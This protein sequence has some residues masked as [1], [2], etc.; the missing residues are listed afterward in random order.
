MPPQLPPDLAWPVTNT[1]LA[2]ALGD[3]MEYVWLRRSPSQPRRHFL[4]AAWIPPDTREDFESNQAVLVTVRPVTDESSETVRRVVRGDLLSNLAAWV[5]AAL[6]Q[7]EE[8]Q[9]QR[10][11]RTYRVDGSAL[12]VG[13]RKSL[14]KP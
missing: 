3:D 10:H 1:Q 6:V 14:G 9:A 2:A 12:V 5:R 8:W 7:D 13:T 11:V 4:S